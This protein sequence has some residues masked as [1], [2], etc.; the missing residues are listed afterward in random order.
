MQ[1]WIYLYIPARYPYVHYIV[2]K[3]GVQKN[4]SE[5]KKASHDSLNNGRVPNE[6]DKEFIEILK[7]R[8]M[9]DWWI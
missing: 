7:S 3:N 1:C 4:N 5:T 6:L 2:Y 9:L 8:G